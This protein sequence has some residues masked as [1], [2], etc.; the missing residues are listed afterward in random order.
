MRYSLPIT[1]R[2]IKALVL[3][4]NFVLTAALASAAQARGTPV[5]ING[6][7]PLGIETFH[8]QPANQDFYLMASAE[9][10]LFANMRRITDANGNRNKLIS[11]NGKVVSVYPESVQFRLTAS[12]REKLLDDKP[13]P[14]EATIPLNE[15]F[16][17]L[18]FRLKIFHG[19]E[20]HYV[21]P[22]Y[23]EDVGMPREVPYN[24]RIYRIGF[25]LG[26]VPIEDRVVMEVFSPS[27][28]RLC[29]FH[30]DLL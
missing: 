11:G 14:T 29:K 9:N 8:L 24:E 19:L 26:K 18:H 17:K 23:V 13:F 25:H 16:V 15:L 22:S 30:L 1:V 5:A 12:S 28:E 27:G 20:Y 7:V 3:T 6:R 21:Q 10:P 2:K 4:L